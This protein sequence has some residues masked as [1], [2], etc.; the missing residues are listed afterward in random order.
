M[1]DEMSITAT[2]VGTLLIAAGSLPVIRTVVRFDRPGSRH[3]RSP[4]ITG[5][6]T[7]CSSTSMEP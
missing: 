4:M 2:V 7:V 1:S 5:V 3:V 6:I